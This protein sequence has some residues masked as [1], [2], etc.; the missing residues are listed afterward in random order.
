MFYQLSQPVVLDGASQYLDLSQHLHRFLHTETFSADIRFQTRDPGY[1]PILAV[2][3]KESLLPDFS[4]SLSKGRAALTINR[5]GCQKLLT[6]GEALCDG[7]PHQLSFRGCR[8]RVSLWVDG[9]LL[10]EDTAPGPWCQFGYVGFA[11]IGRGTRADEYTY[12]SGQILSA[13]LSRKLLE[14]PQ[15]K[16]KS[17]S[18]PTEL[19][20]QGMAG[21]ENYRIPSLLTVGDT[22]IASADAR[23]EAP[24][25]NP[26]HICRAIRISTDSG[27]TWEPVQLFCDYGGT[28]RDDG[29]AAI[30][31]SLLYDSHT[32]TV[33]Q[34][35]SHTS[36]GVGAFHISPERDF[37]PHG[38]KL[39]WD[40]QEQEHYLEQDGRVYRRDGQP[41]G[42][43]VDALGKLFRDQ[44]PAG[45]ICHGET[46]LFRQANVSFLQ[47]IR[48]RDGGRTWSD[49][50]D[51]N[52]QVKA[53]WMHF[54]G[55]GPGTGLQLRE[56]SHRGRLIY[57]VYF[58]NRHKVASSGVIYSDDHGKSWR[59]GASVND[60]RILS[61]QRLCAETV[62]DPQANLGECQVTE[63]PG[64]ILRI[65]L[66][67]SSGCHTLTAVSRDGGESWQ[68][69]QSTGL[70]DPRCQSHVLKTHYRGRDIWLFS[71]PADPVSRVR[72]VVRASFDGGKTWPASRLVEPGEFAYSCMTQLPDGQIGLIYEGRNLHQR[73]IKFPLPWLLEGSDLP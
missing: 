64:G 2:Y 63:L 34:L 48:S 9:A 17:P 14:L 33:F 38:R 60:G 68:E 13:R 56:G 25:D 54:I 27:Q 19:F 24:G 65:F 31:G 72:G 18:C 16:N 28:G 6:G 62:T 29:A 42:F 71:N 8:D 59:R 45:S 35:F 39:L 57:P 10:L 50:V 49:P 15:P 51:L 61:G 23:M 44:T 26:N 20:S 12:F 36:R 11:T 53:P 46:P 66:R 3:F 70:P 1:P 43:R 40:A 52:P 30:D 69:L 41:T 4:L 58:H 22:T 37:D 32:G 21:V 7:K 5:D 47:L 55:A 67:N 73:F